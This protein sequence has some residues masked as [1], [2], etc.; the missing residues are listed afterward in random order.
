MKPEYE[1]G[2]QVE[3]VLDGGASAVFMIRG[4]LG[5]GG[6]AV[7]YAADDEGGGEVALK[8]TSR[9]AVGAD[10]MYLER[11]RQEAG[12]GMSVRHPN[13]CPVYA[14]GTTR[15]GCPAL[16]M[17]PL[18]GQTLDVELDRGGPM[19]TARA[20]ALAA[21]A[22]DG[23]Q[24]AYA[25]AGVIHKDLKPANLFV[26]RQ[27]EPDERLVVT[28][29]GVCRA[30]EG[31]PFT[32]AGQVVGTARYM[33]PEYIRTQSATPALDVY[34]MGLIL[35]EM[36]IGRAVVR[37]GTMVGCIYRHLNGTLEIPASVLDGPLGQVVRGALARD[38][39]MRYPDPSTFASA[40]RAAG[41]ASHE[42]VDIPAAV[43]PTAR[44]T[45]KPDGG[46]TVHV[47]AMIDRHEQARAAARKGAAVGAWRPLR[48]VC[49]HL[50]EP[51]PVVPPREKL[52]T[53]RALAVAHLRRA[54]ALVG[55]AETRH[56]DPAAATESARTH[57]LAALLDEINARWGED[58]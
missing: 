22:L 44:P 16:S 58:A 1:V 46:K 7:V 21:Q 53:Y 54:G 24:A 38:P 12:V 52:T 11:F 37:E 10:P 27:G 56:F 32:H 8:V 47:G 13:V 57:A 36:L 39:K 35:V 29:F 50:E 26:V 3:V 45:G 9:E 28:D 19:P 42:H 18:A 31:I 30:V 25:E 55:T 41:A 5:V 40:L 6:F 48:D 43:Q 51:W 14:W 49:D 2:D 17:E 4:V 33:A 15:N 20:A 34:Q 23:L